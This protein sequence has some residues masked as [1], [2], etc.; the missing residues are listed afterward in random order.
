MLQLGMPTLI[1]TNT[2]DECAVLCRELQLDFVELNMNLPQ[3]QLDRMDILHFKQ[4]AN[5]YGIFYTIHL[6]ENL[7]ISDFNPYIAEGYR[8]T[9]TETIELARELGIPIINMHL[10]CGV[11]FTLPD[12]KIYLFSR[13]REQYLKS[14]THFRQICEDA[15]HDLY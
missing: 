11:Y 3:Y 10:S 15:V 2:L 12:R 1:E 4:I 8:R 13:Y 6:D 5:Q 14:I 9:V 7:N